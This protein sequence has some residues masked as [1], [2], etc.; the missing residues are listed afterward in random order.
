MFI[1]DKKS[2]EFEKMPKRNRDSLFET[3]KSG[4]VQLARLRHPRMLTVDHPLDESKYEHTYTHTVCSRACT[5][6]TCIQRQTL[7]YMDVH[8]EVRMYIRTYVLTYTYKLALLQMHFT[9]SVLH[10]W[11]FLKQ[12]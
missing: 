3:F 1:L 10:L 4:P 5:Q 8:Y 7:V 2:K 9:L 6:T 11:T 12:N